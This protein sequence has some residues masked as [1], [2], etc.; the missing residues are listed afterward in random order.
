MQCCYHTQMYV[1][2][3]NYKAAFT[4]ERSHFQAFYLSAFSLVICLK[5]HSVQTFW[6]FLLK[7]K[8]PKTPKYASK[9]AHVAF[10][11]SGIELQASEHSYANGH[12]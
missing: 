8:N 9:V 10:E 12:Q 7:S 3:G 4:S 2:K 5:K 11:V 1:S 6:A